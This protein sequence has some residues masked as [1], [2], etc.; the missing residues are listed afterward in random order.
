MAAS[1]QHPFFKQLIDALP[2]W[3]RRFGTTY[4]TVMF[5]TGPAFVDVQAVSF[6]QRQRALGRVL[7]ER[8]RLSIMAKELYSD[9]WASYFQHHHGSSWHGA[10]AKWIR[11]LFWW[12]MP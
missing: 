10:D 12:A 9:R 2:W 1:P 7:P 5:S 4:P 6:L 8:D 3:N 11:R